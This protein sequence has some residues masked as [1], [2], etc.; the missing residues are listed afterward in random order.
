MG[1][2][3]FPT[4]ISSFGIPVIG[5]G[6]VPASPGKYLFVDYTT[7]DDGRSIKSQSVSRPLKTL[8]RALD[9]ATTNKDDVIVLMGNATHTLTEMLD[10]SKNRV[11]FVGMDATT[12][13]YG[14]NAKVSLGVTTAATDIATL[15][16]T[17]IRCSFHNIKFINSNTVAQGIYCVA[18]GGEYT[19]FSFCEFYK[20]TDLDQTGA[21]EFLAN[22]DSS[23]Y[24]GCTF[25]SLVN[26]ISGAILRPCVK[27][28]RETITGKVA[29]DVVF[30]NC[31]FWRK[32]GDTAN[33]YISA[34]GA[35]DVERMMLVKNCTFI[36]AKLASAAPAECVKTASQ[37]EGQVLIQDCTSIN[38]TKLS[39][40]TGVL[41]AGPVPTYATTGIA[42]QS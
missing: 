39:T 12:R 17:G 2:T 13:R 27:V 7:G 26:A 33:T 23:Q 38:N 28:N 42:V 19:V 41:I 31:L 20:D 15:Q 32:A 36:N 24:Y 40:S 21:A 11:H 25:G 5:G 14:Q 16:V 9:Y 4:G 3:H 37:T 34:P 6:G 29:R 22:G 10:V 30:E 8:D 1:L 18:D 35:T